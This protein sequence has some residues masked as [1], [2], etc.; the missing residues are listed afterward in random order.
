MTR[1]EL[2]DRLADLE[3]A[4]GGAGRSRVVELLP[5]ETGAEAIRR[6]GAEG[7]TVIL[8]ERTHEP[9]PDAALSR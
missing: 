9:L 5:G 7:K 8:I 2:L 4:L 1:R 3:Q 6:S